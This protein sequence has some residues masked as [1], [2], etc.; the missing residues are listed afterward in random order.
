MKR[1]AVIFGAI[2][3]LALP[4]SLAL[5][6][7]QSV[8]TSP[9][10]ANVGDTIILTGTDLGD[11]QAVPV[12]LI[13]TDGTQYDLGTFNTNDDG[14]LNARFTVPTLPFGVYEV[15]VVGIEAAMTNFGIGID[16]SLVPPAPAMADDD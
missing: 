6:H 14:D 8:T 13:A 4:T 15:H 10:A 12:H 5:A 9:T 11:S 1:A 2:L 7:G 16:P 3:A